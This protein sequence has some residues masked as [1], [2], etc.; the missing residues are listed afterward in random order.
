MEAVLKEFMKTS[1]PDVI[2]YEKKK[3]TRPKARDVISKEHLAEFKDYIRANPKPPPAF[4]ITEEL[5]DPFITMGIVN[6]TSVQ[7]FIERHIP[8]FPIY[9]AFLY[10]TSCGAGKTL[11]GLYAIYALKC[12]TLIISARNAIN[13][14]WQSAINKCF[15][16]LRVRTR[17]EASEEADIYIYSP[18]YL[19]KKFSNLDFGVS[20]IIYDEIHS[21]MSDVFYKVIEGPYKMVISQKWKQLPYF[22]GLSA[23]LPQKRELLDLAFGKP[24]APKATITE[25]PIHV[26]DYRNSFSEDDRG[27]LDLRY[28]PPSD[29][30]CIKYFVNKITEEKEITPCVEYKGMVITYTIDSGVWAALYIHKTWNINVL[31]I[32]AS[33]E[34]CLFL[35][36]DKGIDEEFSDDITLNDL[37]KNIDKYGT[38]C[39]LRD[40]LDECAIICGCFHRLKEG[41][42]VENC[43]WGII[44]K[45]VWCVESRVQLLGRIRRYSLD[46]NLN[47][48]YRKFYTCSGKVPNNLFA[49]SKR[50]KK[51]YRYLI[52]E[53]EIEYDFE[54]ERKIFSKENIIMD[55]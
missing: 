38:L 6:K 28:N 30:E 9:Q 46:E 31:I 25:I 54:Y 51:N 26:W 40:K 37:H 39:N 52:H 18:Q 2:K 13:D 16:K 15:P 42:S 49:L 29:N 24:W 53:A 22:I 27:T 20:L 35:E 19:A 17:E 1:S 3:Y 36:K 21:L 4:L 48:H 5:V 55:N 7:E 14:Q 32:R 43:T 33:G 47:K 34:R 50:K 44:T 11:A 45:F 12:K 10:T 8:L 23:T 41:F